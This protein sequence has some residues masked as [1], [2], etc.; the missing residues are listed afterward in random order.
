MIFF[1]YIIKKISDSTLLIS[2]EIRY[3]KQGIT[4]QDYKVGVVGGR[5]KAEFGQLF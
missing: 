2:F 3:H 1:N 5:G 4:I